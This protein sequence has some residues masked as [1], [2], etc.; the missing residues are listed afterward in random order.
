[1]LKT[2]FQRTLN[3]VFI[4]CIVY[5]LCD[6]GT[7]MTYLCIIW[8]MHSVH[9]HWRQWK[10]LME[11]IRWH[12]L[13]LIYCIFHVFLYVIVV[14]CQKYAFEYNFFPQYLHSFYIPVYFFWL[15]FRSHLCLR[16]LSCWK[17][18]WW[19]W[20]VLRSCGDPWQVTCWRLVLYII[21]NKHKKLVLGL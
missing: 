5:C 10:W 18:A 1:M 15:L 4:F 7:W 2:V 20:I 6:L 19:T 21:E 14:K 11:T 3:Y 12:F 8:S 17:R 9:S 13:L 16:L